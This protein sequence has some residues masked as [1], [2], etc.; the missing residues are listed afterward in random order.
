M[1]KIEDINH[2]QL[3]EHIEGD[4]LDKLLFCV[5]CGDLATERDHVPP[6]T[7]IDDYRAQ[8]LKFELFI[9]VPS[10]KHCNIILGDELDLSIVSRINRL[11]EYLELKRPKDNPV[12]TVN[13]LI[14]LDYALRESVIQK[15]KDEKNIVKKIKY[16]KG[17]YEVLQNINLIYEINFELDT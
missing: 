11:K 10:C 5:Y 2:K 4:K 7:R 14:E 17:L 1:H 13:E 9:T 16:N 15:L 12:W 8:R 3:Y 6:K